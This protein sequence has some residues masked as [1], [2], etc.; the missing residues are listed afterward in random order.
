MSL[1]VGYVGMTHLGLV[2]AAGT[3]S[4]GFETLCCDLDS[5]LISRLK[6]GGL[7]IFEP[8]LAEL[9]AENGTRQRFSS[10]ID[11][12]TACDLVYI[13]ADI[14]TDDEGRSDLAGISRL[15]DEVIPALRH[16]ALLIVLCQV[17][18]GFTRSIR[19]PNGRL[20][21]Q[22]ETLIFGLAVERA[23]QP[24]RI[25]IGYADPDLALPAAYQTLLEA[26]DC[27]ILPM[28][29]ESAELAKISI[30][31]CLAA[32]VTAANT[33]A[34]LCEQIGADWSEIAPALKLDRR[35][36]PHAYLAPG[37]GIAGGN[38]ERDL[39]T[40]CRLAD[41]H[42]SDAR[43]IRACILNSRYRRDWVLRMLHEQVLASNPDPL[44]G[45][46][47]LTYKADTH[48]TKNSPSLAL[49]D[50]L[51]PFALQVFDPVASAAAADHLRA[52]SAESALDACRDADA[53]LIMT[54]WRQF[55]E[56]RPSAIAMA[57]RGTLVIDP[58][59]V[60]D[61]GASA[62]AGLR[63]ITL[64]RIVDVETPRSTV[65]NAAAS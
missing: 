11:D 22:V 54:P 52:R 23:A 9:M 40:A 60:L 8:G 64:G 17:P 30:N 43:F 59:A 39:A 42:G 31:I 46:L 55:K 53:L 20:F 61:A 26:F 12:L 29:Y 51:P 16:D 15:I 48:S 5:A 25:I 6:S 33:M 56:L 50:H 7:P 10:S 38:L 2:S 14:P 65:S 58:F 47:G 45:I 41:A 49:L 28:R 35:I 24:E 13:A 37:L 62:A 19:F 57:M 32:S 36:G 63:H 4:K 18:P 34:E 21:Y 3:C 1:T 27:P 44:I